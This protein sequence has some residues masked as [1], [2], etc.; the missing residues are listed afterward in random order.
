MALGIR[1][2]AFECLPI[3]CGVIAVQAVCEF[4]QDHV[5]EQWSRYKEKDGIQ[6]DVSTVGA[7]APL[8]RSVPKTNATDTDI[9]R[10]CIDAPDE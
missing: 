1:K 10:F 3:D 8:R 9:V 6:H 4:V 5:S 2:H 7:A